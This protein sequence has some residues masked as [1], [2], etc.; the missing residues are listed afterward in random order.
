MLIG[1]IFHENPTLHIIMILQLV[2]C[3]ENAFVD[4]AGFLSR[5]AKSWSRASLGTLA[6]YF[7]VI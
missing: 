5:A 6:V 4:L 3:L 2:E 7:T 1:K